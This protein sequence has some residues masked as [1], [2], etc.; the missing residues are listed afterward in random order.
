MRPDEFLSLWHHRLRHWSSMFAGKSYYH[1]PQGIG[2]KFTPGEL[3]G[4]FNDLTG[5]TKWKGQTDPSG[6]PVSTLSNGKSVHFPIL[7]CQKAL[8]H[9]DLWLLHG[10][11]E[12]QEQFLKLAGWLK[13]TQDSM[14]GW[15]TWGPMGQPPA[16]RYSAMTQGQAISVMARAYT[17]T[18]AEGFQNACTAAMELMKRPVREGGVC[19]Y[20][21]GNVFLEEF[22]AFGRDTVLNGW[23][24]ALFGVYDYQLAFSDKAGTEFFRSTC[25]SLTGSLSAFDRG[26][27]S[28]YSCG[29]KRLAS[30]FYHSLHL[31]QLEAL[32]QITDSPSVRI[33]FDSWTRCQNNRL[34]KSWAILVK[35][36]QK[37]R[38]PQETTIV[39]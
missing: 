14:G 15:D 31:S 4:Y 22:P 10:R 38:E 8:G 27:W 32:R 13:R 17:M 3:N 37:L 36:C 20:E 26:Y 30:P 1:Q 5:K 11:S 18:P 19:W 33:A 16:Y 25:D 6:L 34:Y 23:L 7:L 29:S 24:F 35:A 21:A 2:Q 9:W 39:G 12:D 28:L